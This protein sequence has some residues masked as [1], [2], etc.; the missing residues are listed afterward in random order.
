MYKT[1]CTEEA[2]IKVIGKVTLEFKEFE[3]LQK[4]IC[5]RRLMEEALY[6]YNIVTKETGLVVSDIEDKAIYFFASKRLDGLSEKTL[7]NYNYILIKF[8]S[9]LIKPL[10]T[11]TTMDIRMFLAMYQSTHGVGPGTLN[12]IIYCLKSFFSWLQ[13]EDYIIKN[14]LS[15]IKATKQPK[16][17][18]TA[19]NEEEVELI[20]QACVNGRE[21]ALIE[22]LISTG[23]R[24]SEIVN[25]DILDV[26]FFEMSIN[27]IGKG[28]KERKVLFSTKA[29]ILMQNY[30]SS[31]KDECPA[32]FVTLR[33]PVRRVGG[34]SI[35][36]EIKKIAKRVGFDKSIFPHLFRHSF[37]THKLNSGMSLPVLQRLMGHE[38]SETTLLY[39]A[40]NY[41]T[42][43]YEYKRT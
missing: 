18:R 23:C 34:R 35:E 33:N 32:L 21:K 11:I 37:G 1:N 42:V 36:R 9:F 27:V 8:S 22:C 26:N 43:K 16:R 15:K 20:K 40:L 14:P 3:D 31:R 6:S 38:S 28:D 2:I 41:D 17:L 30:I 19:L 25:I 10:N 13:Q 39:A 29:K 5:L 4:Q 12:S 7:K 24:L